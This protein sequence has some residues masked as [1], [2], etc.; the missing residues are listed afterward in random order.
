LFFNFLSVGMTVAVKTTALF[1]SFL[2]VFFP[3]EAD[4]PDPTDVVNVLQETLLEV[5]KDAKA[6]GVTGRYEKLSPVL[7]RAF[8][9]DKMTRFATGSSWKTATDEQRDT[10]AK[11]FTHLSI[12]NYAAQFSGYSGETFEVLGQRQGPRDSVLVDTQIVRNAAPPVAITYVLASTDGQWRIVDILLE[13]KI[14]EMAVRRS[15]YNPILRE[16]GP[17]A[18][19]TALN[20]KAGELLA[21]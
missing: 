12:S 19:T 10:L 8:D 17:D 1:F 11:A 13:K 18:L 4:Q 7:R 9:F 5:M 6:L 3:V 20:S 14:S 16:G 2:L 15:E 21:Q